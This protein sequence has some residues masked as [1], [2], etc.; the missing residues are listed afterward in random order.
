[1][2][3]KLLTAG[4]IILLG[5]ALGGCFASQK[6]KLAE[7]KSV[8]A[9]KSKSD[10]EVI[11][12]VP[13]TAIQI[14]TNDLIQKVAGEDFSQLSTYSIED[15]EVDRITCTANY[16]V[17][18]Y[19][20]NGTET[21]SGI[22]T[23]AKENTTTVP[24]AKKFIE[25][26]INLCE[27]NVNNQYKYGEIER[28]GKTIFYIC[29]DDNFYPTSV[30]F[31]LKDLAKNDFFSSNERC[32]VYEECL[33]RGN[34]QGLGELVSGYISENSPAESDNVFSVQTKLSEILSVLDKCEVVPDEF[35][36]TANIYYSGIKELS[37]SINVIPSYNTAEQSPKLLVGFSDSDWTFFDKI[38]FKTNDDFITEKYDIGKTN[39]DVTNSGIIEKATFEPNDDEWGKLL[40][41]ASSIRFSNSQ[42]DSKI[43]DHELS[44]SEI[45]AI[46]T[47]SVF[48][49]S[50]NY[51]ADLKFNYLNN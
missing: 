17:T 47:I 30:P 35:E 26:A 46:S 39:R 43:K 21:A 33:K 22:M 1:M 48:R 24:M 36:G 11:N 7:S 25:G 6:A 20:K 42:D 2:K 29:I 8:S 31:L 40:S 28:D 45:D 23:F 49:G 5:I 14:T 50:W 44:D 19:R 37:D 51:F 12:T 10:E 27:T 41:G 34:Y 9:E 4:C 16:G 18:V 32:S 3:N 38:E 13:P 15:Y